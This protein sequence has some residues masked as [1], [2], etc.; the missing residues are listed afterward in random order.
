MGIEI[1][2]GYRPNSN[3]YFPKFFTVTKNGVQKK[4]NQYSSWFYALSNPFIIII[5]WQIPRKEF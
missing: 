5:F 2:I 3:K 1:V 4:S